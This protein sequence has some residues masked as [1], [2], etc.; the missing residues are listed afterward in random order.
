MNMPNPCL[1]S[2][3]REGSRAV[4]SVASSRLRDLGQ[5]LG[6]LPRR[7][8]CAAALVALAGCGGGD[9]EPVMVAGASQPASTPHS[10]VALAATRSARSAEVLQCAADNSLA[11]PQWRVGTLVDEQRWLLEHMQNVYLWWREIPQVDAGAPEFVGPDV[12]SAMS[13]YFRALLTPRLFAPGV[14]V[15]RFSAVVPTAVWE[16]YVGTPDGNG[17]G[18]EWVDAAPGAWPPVLRVAR[19]HPS[20]PAAQAG[21][22][23][24]DRL[25]ALDLR[26]VGSTAA[27][28]LE[29]LQELLLAPREGRTYQLTLL[30]SSA[31]DR[32][33]TVTLTPRSFKRQIVQPAV[34]LQTA[35][36][37]VGYLAFHEHVGAAE[38]PLVAAFRAM[39]R[40]GVRDLVLDLRYN[41]GGLLAM[42][43]QVSTMI[44]G[45]ARTQ[46]RL[47]ARLTYND[48]RQDL[49]DS[50]AARVPFLR[51]TQG[52]E[53]SS[54]PWG[55]ALPEL[56][57]G[58]VFVLAGPGTCSASEAIVNGLRGIG[59]RVVLIGGGSCGK[60]YASYPTDACGITYM[61]LEAR[62]VNQRGRSYERG[63]AP[64]CAVADD[65]SRPLGN[66]REGLLAA[67]LALRSG[68]SCPVGPG[69]T[70]RPWSDGAESG[71]APAS[72]LQ[73]A[74]P[75]R[76]AWRE[77]AF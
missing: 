76:P 40:A 20:S 32:E 73:G 51:S 38:R 22:R 2:D 65:L 52:F 3:E 12:P 16:S 66:P 19:V 26:P 31:L 58:R 67:A 15:D 53:G 43:S 37:P 61:P 71:T 17:L 45:S 34:I 49:S 63:F 8:M 30:G 47:F 57:L 59:V 9:P 77:L 50:P 11:P 62:L 54:L 35:T 75:L 4:A 5:A 56:G 74:Q 42:A 6:R 72:V 1:H 68:G 27:P 41:G 60:P 64:D 69:G 23:R 25:T 70:A 48:R 36:G 7:A 44:A 29:A 21:V 33:R 46:G 39:R 18:I 24:G 55:Q 14:P 28:A 13:S 10:V